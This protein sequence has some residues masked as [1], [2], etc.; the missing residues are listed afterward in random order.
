MFLHV[1]N[2][3]LLPLSVC[4]SAG[5]A[6]SGRSRLTITV[7]KQKINLLVGVKKKMVIEGRS[8]NLR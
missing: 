6:I 2:K 4:K 5:D 7:M 3:T 8:L 1:R